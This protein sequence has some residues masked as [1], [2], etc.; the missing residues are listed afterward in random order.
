MSL[1]GEVVYGTR[2][3]AASANA[4]INPTTPPSPLIKSL[5]HLR[6]FT[7]AVYFNVQIVDHASSGGAT[8]GH[9]RANTAG[10]GL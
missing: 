1:H 10:L 2:T 4:S 6:P 5:C 9:A 7:R 3:A 8:P